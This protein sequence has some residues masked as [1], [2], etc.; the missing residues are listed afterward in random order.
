MHHPKTETGA[1]PETEYKK[2]SALNLIV[3]KLVR[4]HTGAGVIVV[5]GGE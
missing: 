4:L 2:N 1:G 5:Q 3:I